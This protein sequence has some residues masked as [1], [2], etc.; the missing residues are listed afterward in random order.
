MVSGYI[1][2]GVGRLSPGSIDFYRNCL[3]DPAGTRHRGSPVAVGGVQ[4]S[5][6]LRLAGG[7]VSWRRGEL[8]A[9]KWSD[10]SD[11]RLTVR[12]SIVEFEGRPR[13]LTGPVIQAVALRWIEALRASGRGPWTGQLFDRRSQVCFLWF[14]R[15]HSCCFQKYLALCFNRHYFHLCWCRKTGRPL[16]VTGDVYVAETRR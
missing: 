2:D 14:R 10:F 6:A 7:A 12:R 9:L 13:V 11:G 3:A 15:C 5:R 8:V 1:A 16:I 4:L